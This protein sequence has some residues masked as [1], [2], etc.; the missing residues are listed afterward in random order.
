METKL[1]TDTLKRSIANAQ[2]HGWPKLKNPPEK[3]SAPP[4]TPPF[5]EDVP[6]TSPTRTRDQGVALFHDILKNPTRSHEEAMDTFHNIQNEYQERQLEL[7]KANIQS[8]LTP[9][10]GQPMSILHDSESQNKQSAPPS[11]PQA[12]KIPAP[13]ITEK[14][15][16]FERL[17]TWLSGKP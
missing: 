12:E 5:V 14:K 4:V 3:V 13:V 9:I 17:S 6:Q 10:H 16:V 1:D 15:N 7:E 11:S 2:E 8:P